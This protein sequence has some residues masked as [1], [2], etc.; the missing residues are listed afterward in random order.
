MQNFV[1]TVPTTVYFGKGQI[2]NL[3]KEACRYGK[4]ALIVY[5]GG[6]IKRNGIFDAAVKSLQA[7]GVSYEELGGVEP[8]PRLTTVEKGAAACREKGIDMVIP[9]GG[10]SAID[11]AK[12]IAAAAKYD[13]DAWDLVL[14]PSKIR[15]ALPILTVLTLAAT[16]SEMDSIAVISNEETKQKLGT[17]NE[18]MRPKAS[19]LDPEYTFSVNKYQTGAGTADMMSHVLENYFSKAEG[20][21]QDRVAEAL[22][23]TIIEYGITALE[24]PDDYEARANLM[25]TGSWAINDFLQLGKPVAWSVHP[26]E[27]ELSAYY[28][29]THGA[30]LAILTPHWMRAV[31]NDD[32]V[33][34]FY[35]YGINVWNLEESSDKYE[36]ANLAIDCTAAFFE[37]LEMPKT[38]RQAGI[39]DKLLDVMA[40]HAAEHLAG[41]Y[42]PLDKEQVLEIYKKAL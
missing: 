39:D 34:K 31:L 30:G 13:K 26:M 8:N 38:L 7:C 42:V 18:W 15:D 5:G 23:K 2:E 35:T 29:I 12:V 16:G 40:E 6:S 22:L 36:V 37:E 20:F 19:V 17:R 41:A 21:M 4:K 28:D 1:Y 25:W 27:H 32:T 33:D 11:C 9:I 14:D 10:G 24:H 3:G